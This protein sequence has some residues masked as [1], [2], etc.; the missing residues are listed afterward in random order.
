M[1]GPAAILKEIHR[2]RIHAKELQ[3]VIDRGPTVLKNQQAKVTK[4]EQL[5]HEGQEKLKRLKIDIHEKD[6]SLKG[7][8]QQ[9]EK[10]LLQ[11]N[12]ASSKKEYDA[13]KHE[14]AYDRE[15]S[16]ALEDEILAAMLE[17]DAHSAR[18]PELEQA[19]KKAKSELSQFEVSHQARLADVA[20][21]LAHT[22]AELKAVESSLN[23]D[24][25]P[26]YERLMAVRGEDAMSAVHGRTCAACYTEITA[27]NYN[28]LIQGMFLVC[29]SCGR[30]LYLAE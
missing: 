21:Q 3:T 26:A 9:I 25:R 12:S 13:L 7:K 8:A 20:A 18:I 14:I 16:K 28:E 23:D 2:L 15:A 24:V 22:L 11:M 30:F 1:P 19:V 17:V 4:Q 29:K 6:V 5:L 27:Q 10:H